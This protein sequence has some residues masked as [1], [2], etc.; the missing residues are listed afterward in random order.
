MKRY[1]SLATAGLLSLAT[2]TA[3]QA[4]VH[5]MN[6]SQCDGV[7]VR[8][9]D[10]VSGRELGPNLNIV[11]FSTAV[12][13][14]IDAELISGGGGGGGASDTHDRWAATGAGGG[15]GHYSFE[16]HVLE[17][18]TY[19]I[20]IGAG[21]SAGQS[22]GRTIHASDGASGG[23]TVLGRCISDLS[24]VYLDGGAGGGADKNPGGSESRGSDGGSLTHPNTHAVIGKG[25][26]GGIWMHDG[27]DGNGRGAGGG[28]EGG[29]RLS[30]GHGGRGSGGYAR[31]VKI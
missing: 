18:G 13:V 10:V 4:Q 8:P 30:G 21:G 7:K 6:R 3:A 20:R 26:L 31:I 22:L 11:V 17:P 1:H 19:F 15:S 5:D 12:K 9:L 28:G 23:A 29:S 27:T 2:T 25:G 16:S 24:L 14:T